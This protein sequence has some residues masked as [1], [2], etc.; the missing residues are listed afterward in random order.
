MNSEST[1]IELTYK[2][3]LPVLTRTMLSWRVFG[4]AFLTS[5]LLLLT[6]GIAFQMVFLLSLYQGFL[7]LAM[8]SQPFYAAY[9]FLSKNQ[10]L[11]LKLPKPSTFAILASIVPLLAS[12]MFFYLGIF[13]LQKVGFCPQ[14]IACIFLRYLVVPSISH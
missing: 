5:I 6:A 12:F 7:R 11:P 9:R 8:I 2:E 13:A 14:S 3:F 4:F 1:S 10:Q